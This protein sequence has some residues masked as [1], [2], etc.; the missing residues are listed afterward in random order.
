[1]VKNCLLIF[2]RKPALGKVK[3]R[4]AEGLGE[5]KALEIYKL[6]LAH[7]EKI[8]GLINAD[9]WIWSTQLPL[10]GYFSGLKNVKFRQQVEGDLG[11]RM[12]YAFQEAF[13]AGYQ[14]V[15]IIGSDVIELQD[16]TVNAAFE[17]LDD[18]DIVLGPAYDGGYYLLGMKLLHES[19]FEGIAWSTDTVA[20]TSLR[21]ALDLDLS[22]SQVKI[23]RDID[24]KED[25]QQWEG[26][27]E[28]YGLGNT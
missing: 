23:H 12:K 17:D 15:I 19:L 9:P 10:E 8:A 22:I 14:K 21:K 28:R 11:T 27:F 18:F 5:A 6:L 13:K 16:G 1:M 4:L 25:W 26:R 3:T 2:A 24:T 7:C 20:E